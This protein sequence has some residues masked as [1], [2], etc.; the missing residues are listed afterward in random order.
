[1][2]SRAAFSVDSRHQPSTVFSRSIPS[3]SALNVLLILDSPHTDSPAE[4]ILRQIGCDVYSVGMEK[5]SVQRAASA[6]PDVVVVD[7][8][9]A[10]VNAP[11]EL[12]EIVMS[13]SVLPCVWILSGHEKTVS[14][15]PTKWIVEF[16]PSLSLEADLPSALQRVLTREYSKPPSVDESQ[17]DASLSTILDEI[18]DVI[19]SVSYQTHEVLYLN[20]RAEELFGKPLSELTTL[21]SLLNE[22]ADESSQVACVDF[23][24]QLYS[25]HNAIEVIR[26][27]RPDKSTSEVEILGQLIFDDGGKELRIDGIIRVV[28]STVSTTASAGRTTSLAEFLQQQQRIL[29]L[30]RREDS[31]LFVLGSDAVI[32]ATND[33]VLKT[34]RCEHEQLIGQSFLE[35]SASSDSTA[36]QQLLESSLSS[37]GV[38]HSIHTRL[39]SELFSVAIDLACTSEEIADQG[40]VLLILAEESSPVSNADEE[41][42]RREEI[43]IATQKLVSV[44]SWELELLEDGQ[45]RWRWTK[46]MI[47]VT[48]WDDDRRTPSFK[49]FL[50]LLSTDDQE[51]LQRNMDE[52]FSQR[53]LREFDV[54]VRQRDGSF[55]HVYF[56]ALPVVEIL[57]DGREKVRI[58]GAA[59]DITERKEAE[60]QIREQAQL[61]DKASDAIIVEDLENQI[62]FWNQG[63]ERLYGWSKS[64]A[65][66]KSTADLLGSSPPEEIL[67]STDALSTK[68]DWTGELFQQTKNNATVLAESR[69]TLLKDESGKPRSVLIINTDI[70]AKKKLEN[71]MLRSQRLESIGRLSGGIAHDLNN[72]L[73]PILLSTDVLK[74]LVKTAQEQRMVSIIESSAKRGSDM[75]KQVLV[76]A[77][78]VE[79]EHVI[80]ST[81]TVFKE[82]EKIVRETF[83]R[84]IQVT[85]EYD[86]DVPNVNGDATQLHQVI[87]NLCVNA[88][89]AM[90]EGGGLH[91]VLRRYTVGIDEKL[92]SMPEVDNG[93]YVLIAVEDGGGGI[94]PAIAERIFEPFFSTKEVG[95]G[96]GLGL[97]TAM[98]IVNSHRGYLWTHNISTANGKSG[99]RFVVLL[100]A[101]DIDEILLPEENES[102]KLGNGETILLVDDEPAVR[103]LVAETLTNQGYNVLIANDGIEAVALF[104]QHSE[105]ID[106]VLSDLIMPFVDGTTAMKMLQKIEPSVKVVL[107]SGMISSDGAHQVLSQGAKAFIAKPFTADKLS[108]T[109]RST[110]DGTPS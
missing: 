105:S 96:T 44:G 49:E 78:G 54:G 6:K 18:Q 37:V 95:H 58:I 43:L 52:L 28:N 30:A 7:G 102:V 33:Q 53:E 71:D 5:E 75:V 45:P 8:R 3:M 46:S 104:S 24:T 81:K 29:N 72:L 106:L 25:A 108:R 16:V 103:E 86:R 85:T 97:S 27:V 39:K 21:Q 13:D 89:D 34:L 11:E 38:I 107:M 48:G 68:G 17:R 66:G 69:M 4:P 109:I 14:A 93:T 55:R 47:V 36:V 63:A 65:L 35:L 79:G 57:D 32:L 40:I 59:I 2:A 80:T 9:F 76:F 99:A 64:E 31:M 20:R 92:Q 12:L 101:L 22:A 110:L 56:K 87:L 84:S 19:W 42:R 77:R 74:R 94:L 60:A 100:P 1:M 70:T 23:I 83:P 91:M 98:A 62:I 15:F 26:I 51:L 41:L 61:L 67:V 10:R 90:T 82:V 50:L 73:A 88:R